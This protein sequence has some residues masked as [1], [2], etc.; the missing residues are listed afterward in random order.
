MVLKVAALVAGESM[1]VLERVDAATVCPVTA[2]RY[3]EDVG[4][5]TD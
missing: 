1:V 3:G 5:V 2:I 4:S